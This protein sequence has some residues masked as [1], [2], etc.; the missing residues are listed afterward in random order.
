MTKRKVKL[1]NE[2]ILEDK[3]SRSCNRRKPTRSNLLNLVDIPRGVRINNN[4]NYP[5][6]TKTFHN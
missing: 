6:V 2:E 3:K 1:G 4:I 5:I